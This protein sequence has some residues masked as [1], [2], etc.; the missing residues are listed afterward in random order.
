MSFPLKH[1]GGSGHNFALI[2]QIEYEAGSECRM[3]QRS[4]MPERESEGP[5]GC[6]GPS[7]FSRA[8]VGGVFP[9]PFSSAPLLLLGCGRGGRDRG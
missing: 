1:R 5:A 8:A 3:C 4:H 7:E 2:R 6:A 9:A